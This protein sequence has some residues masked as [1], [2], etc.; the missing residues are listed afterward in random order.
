MLQTE[1][2]A[3]VPAGIGLN[4]NKL[5][6]R[7]IK[8]ISPFCPLTD[9]LATG[10]KLF[11]CLFL[12]T[13]KLCRKG[14]KSEAFVCH[15]NRNTHTNSHLCAE[16]ITDQTPKKKD[17]STCLYPS[18]FTAV[19]NY[20]ST[21]APQT[22]TLRLMFVT[23]QPIQTWTSGIK[24][25]LQFEISFWLFWNEWPFIHTIKCAGIT[26]KNKKRQDYL[27]SVTKCCKKGEKKD[28]LFDHDYVTGFWFFLHFYK[29][30][31]L[32]PI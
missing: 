18:L 31:H 10:S 30:G 17:T 23:H 4:R 3:L 22:H 27:L 5:Q 16:R 32:T 15:T 24:L 2:A 28:C 6:Q 20:Q 29:L 11:Q 12:F 1:Q 13:H 7:I 25:N 8:S 19:R 14:S 21:A 26:I 9:A